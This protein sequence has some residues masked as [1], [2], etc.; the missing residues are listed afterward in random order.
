MG[1][2][3]GGA[4][5]EMEIV[6]VAAPDGTGAG[7]G[8]KR[9]ASPKQ[10]HARNKPRQGSLC[11]EEKQQHPSEEAGGSA[12][13][14]GAEGGARTGS[15]G[16]ISS[17]V[18][19]WDGSGGIGS[20]PKVL[21]TD[22]ISRGLTNFNFAWDQ[23][24]VVLLRSSANILRVIM[25][26]PFRVL[27]ECN[28]LSC[29]DNLIPSYTK[30]LKTLGALLVDASSIELA[31]PSAVMRLMMELGELESDL[32]RK[33]R[34][35]G[36]YMRHPQ[37]AEFHMIN[38]LVEAMGTLDKPKEITLPA[39]VVVA[40]FASENNDPNAYLRRMRENI[41]K[42][43]GNLSSLVTFAYKRNITT[44]ERQST[45]A[46]GEGIG[47]VDLGTPTRSLTSYTFRVGEQVYCRDGDR[48]WSDGIVESVAPLEVKKVGWDK[49]YSWDDVRA[50]YISPD[51]GTRTLTFSESALDFWTGPSGPNLLCR[52]LDENMKAME[53]LCTGGCDC[54]VR[55]V[56]CDSRTWLRQGWFCFGRARDFV[57]TLKLSSQREWFEYSKTSARPFHIPSNPDK[58]YKDVGWI[59]RQDWLGY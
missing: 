29:I 9:G 32:I 50:V 41:A 53:T 12:G 27:S 30:K 2:M 7:K 39:K 15:G 33:R 17:H 23:N 5:G 52:L 35:A 54:T 4:G 20:Q 18:G 59:S 24:Y 34:D 43:S 46:R 47:I 56:I 40:S 58:V 21:S 51:S 26:H 55:G 44:G 6:G 31:D 8:T 45:G 25:S 10:S 36:P 22:D 28:V 3:A 37:Q 49:A 48:E 57:H 19:A 1:G 14:P 11:S 38:N 13:S 16:G 42:A